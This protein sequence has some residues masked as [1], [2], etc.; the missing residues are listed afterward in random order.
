MSDALW[1]QLISDAILAMV[2]V[3]LAFLI[4]FY[5]KRQT[6]LAFK[7]AFVIM[8]GLLHVLNIVTLLAP[9]SLIHWAGGVIKI[10]IAFSSLL[11]AVV[12]W[13][14]IPKA[15]VVPSLNARLA[16]MEV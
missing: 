10:I 8:G 16:R 14:L 15:L 13:P 11:A 7:S 6:S 4:A 3:S 2:F 5:L 9:I 1:L 12:L